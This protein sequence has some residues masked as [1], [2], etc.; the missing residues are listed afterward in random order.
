M[1]GYKMCPRCRGIA[2]WSEN[3]QGYICNCGYIDRQPV[4]M[5]KEIEETE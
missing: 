2:A 1:S 4:Q 3:F 5:P